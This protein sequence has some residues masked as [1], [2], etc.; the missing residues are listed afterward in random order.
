[1][2]EYVSMCNSTRCPPLNVVSSRTFTELILSSASPIRDGVDRVQATKNALS[3]AWCA[4]LRGFSRPNGT[5]TKISSGPVREHES[6]RR[7]DLHLICA[8]NIAYEDRRGRCQN[9][10]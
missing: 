7:F 3:C 8:T 2:G 10:T 4:I 1:M 6:T 9:E 5:C